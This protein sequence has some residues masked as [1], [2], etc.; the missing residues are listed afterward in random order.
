ME[1]DQDRSSK[2]SRP[3]SLIRDSRYSLEVFNPVST[4][5]PHQRQ[6]D[7]TWQKDGTVEPHHHTQ[8]DDYTSPKWMAISAAEDKNA[9]SSSIASAAARRAT[10]WGLVLKTDEKTGRPQGVE[11][12]KSG[13]EESTGV[14]SESSTLRISG[15]SDSVRALPRISEDLKEA[16]SVFQQTFVVS[17]ATMPDC[18]I[19]YASAGFFKMTGY[20]PSEAIGRNWYAMY[21][22]YCFSTCQLQDLLTVL[23]KKFKIYLK[24]YLKKLQYLS[25]DKLCQRLVHRGF[26]FVG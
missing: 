15:N 1:E 23:P 26:T 4:I 19:M 7:D 11:V 2:K 18:P 24:F 12:R 25:G 3:L 10:E 6:T 20:L 8:S 13:D 14:G 5:Q 21:I 9:P 17:D 22:C 16:L